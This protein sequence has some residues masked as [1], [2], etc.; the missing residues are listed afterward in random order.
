MAQIIGYAP[1]TPSQIHIRAILLTI[2]DTGP[3]INEVIRMK[4]K[5]VDRENLVLRVMG[6][7]SHERV[8]PFSHLNCAGC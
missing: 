4:F 2:I 5:D 1:K 6:E 7:G 8:V 3:R